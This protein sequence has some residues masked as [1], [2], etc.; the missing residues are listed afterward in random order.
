MKKN[1][2]RNKTIGVILMIAAVFVGII[3]FANSDLTPLSFVKAK[4][5][6]AQVEVGDISESGALWLGGVMMIGLFIPGIILAI[7]KNKF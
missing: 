2:A 6:N 4:V 5:G 1:A 3:F 7:K